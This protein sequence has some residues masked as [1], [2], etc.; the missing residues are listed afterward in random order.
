MPAMDAAIE[1]VGLRDLTNRTSSIMGR[2]KEGHAVIVT[3]HG[4]PIARIVP[5]QSRAAERLADAIARGWVTPAQRVG[6]RSR[7]DPTVKPV[8]G[9]VSDLVK[10]QR[11]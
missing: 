6:P 4:R 10:E 7:P 2:V 9:L 5:I 1:H 11:A 3:E 8:D